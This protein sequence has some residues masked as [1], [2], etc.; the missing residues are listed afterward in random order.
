[1]YIY[2]IALPSMESSF[3]GLLNNDVNY[4]VLSNIK[5][6]SLLGFVNLLLTLI[7]FIFVNYYNI[8][9]DYKI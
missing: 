6:L 5:N 4:S 8:S 9:Y 1:M 3:S 2:V 7:Y